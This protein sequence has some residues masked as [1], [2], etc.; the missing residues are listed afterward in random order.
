MFNTTDSDIALS[1]ISHQFCAP[2][3]YVA[4][5]SSGDVVVPANGYAEVPWPANFGSDNDAGGEMM[6]YV[7][8]SFGSDASIADYICWGN[9]DEDRKG[10]AEAVGKWTGPCAPAIT[11]GSIARAIGTD[12][13]VA[14]DYIVDE[15]REANTC[16]ATQETTTR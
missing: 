16:T 10:Q 3:A 1:S 12:G 6:L 15:V 8:N 13:T 14:G 7:N 11:N 4:L 2:F 5:S 9:S